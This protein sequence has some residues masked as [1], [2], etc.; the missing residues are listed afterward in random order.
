MPLLPADAE[1]FNG[2]NGAVGNL[3]VPGTA[4][5]PEDSGALKHSTVHNENN[6]Q[7]LLL[8]MPVVADGITE[9]FG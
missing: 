3:S 9:F 1:T 4:E 5:K 2:G 7:A 8:L 6:A